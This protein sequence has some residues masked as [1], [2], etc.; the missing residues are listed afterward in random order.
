METITNV[1]TFTD[2]V[3]GSDIEK[4]YKYTTTVKEGAIALS[5]PTVEYADLQKVVNDTIAKLDKLIGLTDAY[6]DVEYTTTI[7]LPKYTMLKTVTTKQT[8]VKVTCEVVATISGYES[9]ESFGT[10][11]LVFPFENATTE[12]TLGG[13]IIT[14]RDYKSVDHEFGHTHDHGHGH[15]HGSGNAGGGIIEAE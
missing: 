11:E 7:T 15:G 10:V 8:V 4:S 6:K 12:A 1:V 3:N 2:I 9:T 14:E 5:R 13:T